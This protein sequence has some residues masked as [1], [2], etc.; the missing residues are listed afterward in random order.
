MK[1]II[2]RPKAHPN[3]LSIS[4]TEGGSAY[5][6]LSMD[7]EFMNCVSYNMGDPGYLSYRFA[8]H[9]TSHSSDRGYHYNIESF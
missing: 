8:A 5:Y 3:D 6:S 7:Q 4:F 9:S 2:E 1:P